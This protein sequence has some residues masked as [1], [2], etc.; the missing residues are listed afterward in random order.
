MRLT[1]AF[2]LISDCIFPSPQPR[3]QAEIVSERERAAVAQASLDAN[4]ADLPG[5]AEQL[6]P[7]LA[8]CKE[9]LAQEDGR[10]QSVDTR[11]TA[12]VGLSSIAGTIVF[13]GMLTQPQ[14]FRSPHGVA[15]WLLA[16][17]P[18]YLTLQVCSAILAA[19][20]GLGRRGYFTSTPTDV[21][22]TR[23]EAPSV[24]LRRQLASCLHT[25]ADTQVRNDDKVTQ[26]AV[27]H[28]AM[29]NFLVG[30][31]VLGAL[32]TWR[33]LTMAPSDDILD[34]LKRDQ[35]V[36]D[37]LRGP[38]GPIGGPGPKGDP[39]TPCAPPGPSNALQGTHR[40]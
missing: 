19:V 23:D 27:A 22:P 5:K 8:S 28:R 6:G 15:G 3:S 25:L 36:R 31:L 7:Y 17:G 18:L 1:G 13:G 4:I 40:Q 38:Q 21:L 33:A 2:W 9:L 34:R 30:L 39:G 11:L 35:V 16:C 26:M 29:R 14:A 32:G 12:I 37:L 10:R 24:H 20:V